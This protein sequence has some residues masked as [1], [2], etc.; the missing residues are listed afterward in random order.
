MISKK[1]TNVAAYLRPSISYRRLILNSLLHRWQDQMRGTA[2]DIGG[3]KSNPVAPAPMGNRVNRW[4]YLN[5]SPSANPD[6]LADAAHIPLSRESVDTVLCNATLEHVND[7]TRVMSEISRI[8]RPAGVLLLGVPFL[9]RIHSPPN[10]FWRFT[11][12]QLLRMVEEQGLQLVRIERIGLLF[13]VLCDMMKQAISEVRWRGLRWLTWLLFLPVATILVTLEQSGMGKHSTV[14]TRYTTGYL[15]LATR[16]GP[17][18]RR[19]DHGLRG[20]HVR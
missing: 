9:Y 20:R 10:D 12:H 14:L 17:E 1:L 11:E 15:V 2:L 5:I 19:L 7:P 16:P 4:I 13:T 3:I 6:I 8:L 18:S